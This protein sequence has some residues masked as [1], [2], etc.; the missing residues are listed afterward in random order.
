MN[1]RAS[2]R[3]PFQGAEPVLDA[4]TRDRMQKRKKRAALRAQGLTAAG[5]PLKNPKYRRGVSAHPAS[6]RCYDCLFPEG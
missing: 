5:K 6:C 3:R 4:R 2:A 1:A